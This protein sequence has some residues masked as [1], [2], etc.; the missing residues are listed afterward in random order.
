MLFA[1]ESN[2]V[3]FSGHIMPQGLYRIIIWDRQKYPVPLN[4][5]HILE[6]FK[7]TVRTKELLHII[8]CFIYKYNCFFKNEFLIQKI[9]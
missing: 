9:I 5:E 7:K 4:C 2:F 6:Y 8:F 1:C 3:K